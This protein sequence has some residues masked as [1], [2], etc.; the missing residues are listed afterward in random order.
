MAADDIFNFDPQKR[1]EAIGDVYKERTTSAA[2]DI[3]GLF[4]EPNALDRAAA[5]KKEFNAT[6]PAQEP[7]PRIFQNVANDRAGVFFKDGTYKPNKQP[8]QKP[9]PDRAGSAMVRSDAPPMRPAPPRGVSGYA[10][11]RAAYYRRVGADRVDATLRNLAERQQTRQRD[12][13]RER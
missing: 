12:N 10:A 5:P 11:D 4:Y 8:A 2:K 1:R 13:E 6:Q 3:T 7:P 9:E